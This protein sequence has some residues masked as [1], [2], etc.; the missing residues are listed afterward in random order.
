MDTSLLPP[1]LTERMKPTSTGCILWT[2]SLNHAGYGRAWWEGKAR[3]AHRVVL[4]IYGIPV[5]DGFEP[6]HLCQVRNC[7]RLEHL[8][9]ISGT[10][11]RRRAGA[12]Q[13]KCK[14]GHEYTEENTRRRADGARTCRMCQGWTGPSGSRRGDNLRKSL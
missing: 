4:E 9:V 12:R 11:N 2:G 10:E 7:V 1:Y 3:P 6:D 13:T 8:E 5:P 14:K